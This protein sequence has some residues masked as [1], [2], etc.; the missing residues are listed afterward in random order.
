MFHFTL[1]LMQI[2]GPLIVAEKCHLLPERLTQ[3]AISLGSGLNYGF[4]VLLDAVDKVGEGGAPIVRHKPCE[5][6]WAA[7]NLL[8]LVRT[9]LYVG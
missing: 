2:S 3:K 8:C 1:G 5:A 7:L 6:H 9:R 4:R